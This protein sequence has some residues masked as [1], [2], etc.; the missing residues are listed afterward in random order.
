MSII[1]SN[2][3][4]EPSDHLL[5]MGDEHISV[6]TLGEWM[7]QWYNRIHSEE[8]I[9]KGAE[10]GINTLYTH[11]F[12]GF[13]LNHENEQMQRTKELTKIAHRYGM[14]VIGYCTLGTMYYETLLDEVPDLEDWAAHDWDGKIL[15]YGGGNQHY[16]RWRSCLENRSYIDYIKKVI[17]YGIQE[18]GLDG[19]H[20][21]NSGARP[22]CCPRCT[23]AFRQYLAVCIKNP[24]QEV[25][26]NHFGNVRLAP[27]FKSNEVH[28]TIA[29]LS[30]RFRHVQLAK[31]HKE[32]SEYVHEI[33]GKY[34]LCNPG[35]ARPDFCEYLDVEIHPKACDMMF[36]E[37][38][39]YVR[40]EDGKN[41]SQI[42]AFKLGERFGFKIFN[43]PWIQ[44]GQDYIIPADEDTIERFLAEGMIYGNITGAPWFV[45]SRKTGNKVIMD[46]I[47]QQ[48]AAK[49][50]FNYFK[51]NKKLFEAVSDTKVN[52]LYS[53]YSFY[54]MP[55][56]GFAKFCE[57]AQHLTDQNVPYK[58]ITDDEIQ[59][60]P[61]GDLIV[62]YD[63]R[64]APVSQ[65]EAL[66][67]AAMR[68][69]RLV[70]IGHYGLYNENGKERDHCSGVRD[71][72]GLPN[73]ISELP[74]DVRITTD[75]EN[76]FT[77]T[78]VEK[79]GE[80]VLHLLRLDNY[81][82]LQSLRIKMQNP[83]IHE[84]C[85]LTLYS[86]DDDCKIISYSI[87]EGAVDI[88]IANFRTM[89]SIEFNGTGD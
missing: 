32:L 73:I 22:C 67:V 64:Y 25:G 7:S 33:G 83:A 57:Y 24:R 85:H 5:R 38:S 19:I 62:L 51:R 87:Q 15:T 47:L 61:S 72:V 78:R 37:N 26:L 29:I 56:E 44:K 86:T 68:G 21:D 3:N 66:A 55:K 2:W 43:A 34:V 74:D 9:A 49:R 50:M 52:L 53:T 35:L 75:I 80:H 17:K 82:T 88:I 77:E 48:N 30:S 70:M 54:G 6:F 28:D 81:T 63:L 18:I 12:K 65:Y 16:Y 45:R 60:V 4:H 1:W 11:F 89:A 46:D 41:Y 13:G 40:R 59:K 20:F 58:I 10:L 84:K 31:A 76:V 71:L 27:S 8:L 23:T 39:N 79:T 36:A 69:V 42:L 14:D